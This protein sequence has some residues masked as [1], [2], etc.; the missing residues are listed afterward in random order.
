MIERLI[1]SMEHTAKASESAAIVKQTSS[2]LL[3]YCLTNG[4]N[5]DQSMKQKFW[6]Y[7][8]YNIRSN[9]VKQQRTKNYY[10][11][12]HTYSILR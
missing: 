5:K 11:L 10:V 3:N 8:T 4:M 9:I 6:G 1:D 12:K 7:K 2:R